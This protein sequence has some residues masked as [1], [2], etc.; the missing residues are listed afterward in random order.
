MPETAQTEVRNGMWAGRRC[1]IVGGGPS[2]RGFDYSALNGELTIG[3]NR[4]YEYFRPS[5]IFAMDHPYYQSVMIDRAYGNAPRRRLMRSK[6][7][8]LWMHTSRPTRSVELD[9]LM[10]LKH[11]G[12]DGLCKSLDDGLFSGENSGY[13]AINLAVALGCR[14]IY[15]LGYDMHGEDGLAAHFHEGHPTKKPTNGGAVLGEE[16]PASLYADKF[17]PHFDELAPLLKERG[18]SVTN[19]CPDSALTCFPRMSFVEW[20]KEALE[21]ATARAAV[22]E[23]VPTPRPMPKP[24]APQDDTVKR[25]PETFGYVVVSF[26]TVGTSYATEIEGLWETLEELGIP[27]HFVP[28]KAMGT[29][30][31]NLNHKSRCIL[32]AF[33]MFP[34][35]D[36][37]FLDADA[38]VRSMPVL[39]DELSTHHRYDLSAHFYHYQPR[40]GHHD[41]LLSGTIWIKNDHTGRALVQRWHDIAL[42][43]PLTRHQ[44]CLK[45]AIQEF[46]DEGFPVQI[47]RHPFEYTCIFDYPGVKRGE[48]TPIIEHFQASRRFRDEV[49]RGQNLLLTDCARG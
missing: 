2:L 48:V 46:E 42:A 39:F 27:Y 16:L 45:H 32:E 28:C 49:G 15:L 21:W 31:E 1:F 11:A 38:K 24:S 26:Y 29:W 33:D 30:R 14:E 35:K 43:K 20:R 37:V 13:A 19:L 41:E 25:A 44:M 10:E 18:V 4:A 40:S 47:N 23:M 6:A 7:P 12:L 9:G 36:I 22:Q 17:I 3:I 8:K 34:G 5:I